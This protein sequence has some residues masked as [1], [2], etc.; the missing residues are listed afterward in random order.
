M[1]SIACILLGTILL[2]GCA[3]QKEDEDKIGEWQNLLEGDDLA[4]WEQ[5]GDFTVNLEDGVLEISID[6]SMD[7]GWLYTEED[8][9]DFKFEAEFKVPSGVNSGIAFRY[10]D[11]KG[12]HPAETAY[13]VN[14]DHN[15][16]QQNPTGSIYNVARAA[17]LQSTDVNGWNKIGIEA[18]GD[19]LKVSINDTVVSETHDRRSLE[20]KIGL[21][22]YGGGKAVKTA[23]RNIRII[24]FE[25]S[26]Y[27]G[28]QMEDYLRNTIK[29]PMVA[30]ADMNSLDAWTQIG[31]GYWEIEDGVIHGYSGE[32]G[33]FL[34]S[35]EAYHN[36]YLKL[37]FKIIKEDNSG[38]F[39][40][41]DPTSDEVT[42][43]NAIECN[44]YDHN[45]FKHAY[46]T[47]SIALHSRAW[48]NLV[49]YD[50]WNQMEIF[51]FE[52]RVSMFINGIK[53]TE[54]HLPEKFNTKGNICIQGGVKVFL[55]GGPS[56]I[57]IKDIMIRDM[58]DIPFLG[59]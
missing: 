24:E 19:Y 30:L 47:G 26:D 58:G 16:D 13:E 27:L 46:S 28:P 54:K 57:Y 8:Y 2:F 11:S 55:D 14:I 10:E 4:A 7:G 40:R 31:D 12:G 49:D 36:F 45:G 17:W 56:D 25:D 53:S 21:E 41:R 48:S 39:I 59:Y 43:D 6:E 52:D 22:A 35:K 23:F 38:I 44:I 15:Q 18:V 32:E 51:A 37:K 20:G 29:K 1:K 5:A 34:I 33:G 3:N 42:T 9:E 50:D